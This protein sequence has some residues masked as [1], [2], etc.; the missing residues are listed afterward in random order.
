MPP[1]G[2]ASERLFLD[3][4]KQIARMNDWLIHH[5]TPYQVRPGVWRSDDKGVPDLFLVSRR[6]GGIVHAELKTM[7]GRLSEEQEEWAASIV[8]NGGEFHLWRPD[9]L[10]DIARRLGANR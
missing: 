2:D 1:M 3:K 8:R 10:E 7:R 9:N 6:N 5:P 4:V